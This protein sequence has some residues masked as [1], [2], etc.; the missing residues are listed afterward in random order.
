M[1]TNRF[2]MIKRLLSK[3]N[4]S[5]DY[6]IFFT[7]ISTGVT[8][9]SIASG[10]GEYKNE[11]QND[12]QQIESIY[13]EI[14]KSLNTTLNEHSWQIRHFA[15]KILKE[16]PDNLKEI[17]RILRETNKLDTNS[18]LD[19][20]FGVKDINWVDNRD[21]VRIKNK[22]GILKYPFKA[23]SAY[24]LHKAKENPWNL[25][26][27][28]NLPFRKNDYNLI[29]TSFGIT[30]ESGK[31][32]GAITSSIDNNFLSK[33]LSN[34]PSN[35]YAV[36]VSSSENKVILQSSGSKLEK[37]YLFG[38]SIY[39]SNKT[40]TEIDEENGE[41]HYSFYK[42][43]DNLPFSIII[44]Y[45]T[46]ELHIRIIDRVFEAVLP[47]ISVGLLL[48]ITLLIFY[49]R[50]IKP[51][52][53]L[54]EIASNIASK[55]IDD[56]R[57]PRK[58]GS[59]E[60]AKLAK[61]LLLAA[62]QQNKLKKLND[63]LLMMIEQHKTLQQSNDE[64]LTTKYKLEETVT[65]NN[66]SDSAQ[67]EI[68]SQLRNEVIKKIAQ[69]F[70][71]TT[72]LKENISH[73]KPGLSN[74]N[75]SIISNIE[76]QLRNIARFTTDEL[77]DEEVDIRNTLE[78]IIT[79]QEKLLNQRNISLHISYK[80]TVPKKLLL[81]R[82][83]L[84]QIVSSIMIR[85]VETLSKNKN[86]DLSIGTSVRK[87]IKFIS[88]KFTDNGSINIED[89]DSI[90]HSIKQRTKTMSGIDISINAI[91]DLIHLHK[92]HIKIKSNS[93]GSTTT[94]L[95]PYKTKISKIAN[96]RNYSSSKIIQFPTSY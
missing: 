8:L 18:N 10:V 50:T 41:I 46:K 36:I 27:S 13:L 5:A 77:K 61:A 52:G 76:K 37:D 45:N 80:N 3:L 1:N 51:I 12:K 78:K 44:G 88:I 69:T 55:K 90:N 24:E 82:I 26:I 74:I 34:L 92:G 40:N 17:N 9:L 73:N 14:E 60:S 57:L 84:I 21:N 70:Y 38:R 96:T 66:K 23:L 89:F 85:T 43:V 64:L 6:L 68:L 29:L 4:L 87:G 7:I 95:I 15:N 35:Y 28:Q 30:D 31:Y 54:A 20:F 42:K 16:D 86:L 25:I 62:K 53:Q 33:N 79:S 67:V 75:L 71:S 94:I 11:I 63:E 2:F 65:I 48:I 59:P 91:K 81:D 83:I 58:I 49:R 72:L 19:Q 56:L 47:I 22:I 32:L 39:H 93:K